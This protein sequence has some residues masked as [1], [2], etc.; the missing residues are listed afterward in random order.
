MKFIQLDLYLR[1]QENYAYIVNVSINIT[2][3]C[4][5]NILISLSSKSIQYRYF[6][7]IDIII[8]KCVVKNENGLQDDLS[9][10]VYNTGLYS[11]DLL[12]CKIFSQVNLIYRT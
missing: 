8:V 1:L 7:R 6:L 12:F 2:N 9:L 4:I 5:I 3:N 10:L 11:K